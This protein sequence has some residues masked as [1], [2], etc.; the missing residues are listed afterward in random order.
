ML[1]SGCTLAVSSVLFASFSAVLEAPLVAKFL[2]LVFTVIV[3]ATEVVL[4]VALVLARK[5][6]RDETGG[7][8]TGVVL[9]PVN[10]PNA[11]FES[12][13]CN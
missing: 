3:G 12:A 2:L 10:V 11:L 5:L 7:F 9:K 4:E 8:V 6:N 13:P 1:D